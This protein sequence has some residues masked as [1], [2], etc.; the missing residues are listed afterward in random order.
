MKYDAIIFDLDGTLWDTRAGIAACWGRTL[1][2]RYGAQCVPTVEDV[3]S[4][5]GMTEQ[6]IADKLFSQYGDM[7]LEV[8]RTCLK[9][10]VDHLPQ[11][12]VSIYAGVAEML[13]TLSGRYKLFAVSNCQAG[14]ME[15]FFD[16]FNC[17]KYFVDYA[18]E[19]STG[20]KKADNIRL[21]AQ[22]HDLHRA[23]YVG[24]T[25]IDEQSAK[26]AHCDFIHAA[27]GFG[28]AEAPTGCIY[29]PCE[30]PQLLDVLEGRE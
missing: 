14:Y 4:I 21:I 30:L 17:G 24:D 22:R 9:E 1:R 20:L 19:G 13:R 18:T 3:E 23:V 16:L 28:S 29:A 25:V 12:S 26:A 6:E 2:E 7:R 10:E 8:C 27:Y 15:L 11:Y 5:M